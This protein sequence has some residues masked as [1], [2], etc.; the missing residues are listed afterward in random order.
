MLPLISIILPVYNMADKLPRCIDSLTAQTYPNLEFLFVDDG[1]TDNSAEVIAHYADSR[2]RIFRK[3]NGGV[4][5]ARN[6]GLRNMRGEYGAFVDPDDTVSPNYIQYLYD[7]LMA[8]DTKLSCCRIRTIAEANADKPVTDDPHQP[9]K[10]ATLDNYD[11]YGEMAHVQCYGALYHRDL[12]EN[13]RFD[14]RISYAEDTLFYMQAV[15]AA[16]RVAY[17]TERL[18]RYVEW[19]GSALR[20][21]YTAAQYS[22]VTVWADICRMTREAAPILHDSSQIRYCC[23]CT[24]AFYYS[25]TSREDCTALRRDAV[26][27]LRA[28]W[29]WV[30]K[31]PTHSERRKGLI[32]MVSPKLAHW[33]WKRAKGK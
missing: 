25:F 18:Y 32:A 14:E 22:D 8:Y 6:E 19:T 20:K 12:L 17:L 15:L 27:R 26:K 11:Q 4:S 30:M 31:M 16:G 21:A 33:M 7:A 29:R 10:L 13:L 1:S 3:K 9:A 28:S 24:R 2:F 5:S 23:A